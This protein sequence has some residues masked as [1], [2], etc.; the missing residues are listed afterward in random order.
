MIR[1]DQMILKRKINNNVVYASDGSQKVI[2]VGKGIGFQVSPGQ[3]ITKDLVEKVFLPIEDMSLS[4]IEILIS[5]ISLE[6]MHISDEIVNMAV[7]ELKKDISPK[8]LFPL[9][10]HIRFA[11]ERHKHNIEF[12]SPIQWEVK[13]FYPSEVRVGKM[14]LAFIK[15]KTGVEL[16]ESE[17]VFIAL[18]FV[19]AQFDKETIESTVE[20]TEL[21]NS[22]V[23]IVKYYMRI[24]IDEE[25]FM[26]NRFITHLRYYLMRRKAGEIIEFD[27][28]DL[29]QMVLVKFPRE[30]A[31][32]NM[33]I[34]FLYERYQWETPEVE[35]MYLI[36][37]INSLCS[38]TKKQNTMEQNK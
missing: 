30:A 4:Q 3:E 26:Y 15:E 9:I 2:V 32:V 35:K 36:L 16:P 21:M 38:R 20:Y 7:R 8:L 22:I 23:Q 25:S 12:T 33:I 6:D 10:D 29:L 11:M 28:E 19:N 5:D 24:D 34:E 13:K 18:H 31:C 37:H 17:A 14:A 1:G 27:N